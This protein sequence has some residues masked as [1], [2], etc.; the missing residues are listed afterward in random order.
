MEQI[1]IYNSMERLV[2]RCC[3]QNAVGAIGVCTYLR[4][5][6][7]VYGVEMAHPLHI[8]HNFNFM[9]LDVDSY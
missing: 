8:R 5:K 6:G 1:R 2:Y 3:V 9:K 7:P 4:E